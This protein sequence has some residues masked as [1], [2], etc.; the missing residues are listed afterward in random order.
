MKKKYSHTLSD[1]AY[2]CHLQKNYS[3]NRSVDKHFWI[4]RIFTNFTRLLY[5]KCDMKMVME[6]NWASINKRVLTPSDEEMSRNPR[7]CS[8]KLQAALKVKWVF[9][10]SILE[11]TGQELVE[12]STETALRLPIFLAVVGH[13]V[14]SYLYCHY[15]F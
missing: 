9:S 1:F 5:E 11:T 6:K 12:P 2:L 15:V 14:S 13:L 7:R 8:A 4:C 3:S 10:W